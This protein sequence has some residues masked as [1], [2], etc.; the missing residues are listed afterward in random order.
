MKK[1]SFVGN[2]FTYSLIVSIF[3]IVLTFVYYVFNIEVFS[4]AFMAASLIMGI[5]ILSGAMIF[6]V[7]NYRENALGG[8]ITF[9]KAFLHVFTIGIFGYAVIAVFS[10]IFHAFIAP[11]YAAI[12]LEGFIT[13]MEGFGSIPEEIFDESVAD[14]ESKMTPVGQMIEAIKNGAIMSLI[15]GLIVAASIKKDTTQAE[16]S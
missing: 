4:Y 13:F 1:V 9:G 10:Y 14:F 5:L 7:R 2:A 12:Q 15:V 8:I 3:A 6:G 16:I 11:E